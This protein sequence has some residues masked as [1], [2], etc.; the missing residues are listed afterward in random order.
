MTALR[1]VILLVILAALPGCGTSSSSLR[2]QAE[3]LMEGVRR[4]PV[5]SNY[6]VQ[7]NALEQDYRALIEAGWWQRLS[8]QVSEERFRQFLD[9]GK[10]LQ[11]Q[12]RAPVSSVPA[13]TQTVVQP[14]TTGVSVG[15]VSH[16]TV[17]KGDTLPM[18]AAHPQVYGDSSLWPLLYKANRDQVRDPFQLYPGQSLRIPRNMSKEEIAEAYRQ[19]GQHKP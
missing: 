11:E 7:Y 18:V 17:K 14:G 10:Q 9:K 5:H 12:M 4:D 16:Y 15:L 6:S 3:S 13:P 8:G 2:S 1:V 19:A